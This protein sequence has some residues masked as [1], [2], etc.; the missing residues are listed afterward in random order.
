[1]ILHD[2][3]NVSV[4]GRQRFLLSPHQKMLLMPVGDVHAGSDGWP[5][6]RF[7]EHMQWGVD[8]GARFL[9]MGEYFDFTSTTQRQVLKGLRDSQLRQIDEMV[10]QEVEAF[11]EKIKTTKGRWLGMLEGHHFHEYQDGTTSD[12]HLCRLMGTTFLGTSTL[13]RVRLEDPKRRSGTKPR[14]VTGGTEI[15]I[16]AHHGAAGGGAR[17][18]GSGLLRLEDLLMWIQADIYL[19]GHIHTKVN[20]PLQQLDVT[21]NG[22]LYHRTKI[23]ARTGGFLR[24]YLASR[25]HHT[26]ARAALSRGG[27]V[28][29]RLLPPA[30]LGGL[31]LGL[32]YKR[33]REGGVDITIPDLRCSA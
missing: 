31:V 2:W 10:A 4:P 27:Y 30:T 25:P 9:G 24:G 6:R 21:D 23:I 1:M 29:Q 18:M 12:Q 8:Q 16:F 5:E 13:L 11:G 14:G 28:E 26:R 19:M 33:I 17:R 32:G 3:S 22:T 20:A 15:R 7:L